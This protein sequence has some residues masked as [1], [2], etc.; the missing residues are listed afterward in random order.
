MLHMGVEH[1][2]DMVTM[3]VDTARGSSMEDMVSG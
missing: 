3:E 1:T 2:E